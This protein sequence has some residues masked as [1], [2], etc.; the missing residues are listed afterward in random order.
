M[1]IDLSTASQPPPTAAR[2]AFQ[3]L[4]DRLRARV[5]GELAV[6]LEAKRAAASAPEA[7]ELVEGV[8]RLVAQG[9]KRLRPALVCAAYRACGGRRDEVALPL[10]AS[11]DVGRIIAVDVRYLLW[12]LEALH[13]PQAT[14]LL[15]E[16]GVTKSRISPEGS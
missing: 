7:R 1:T 4:L 6:F 5:D 2:P 3:P 8:A 14:P 10:P 9:G 13:G 12:A 11:T 16:F 15:Q